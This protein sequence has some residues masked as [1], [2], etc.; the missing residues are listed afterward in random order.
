[1]KNFIKFSLFI[2]SLMLCTAN[3]ADLKVTTINPIPTTPP[4]LSD[5]DLT[6]NVI[7]AVGNNHLAASQ[8][9]AITATNG[10]ITLTGTVSNV[11]DATNFIEVVESVTGVKDV[12]T[13]SL[14]LV[15]GL[16]LPKDRVITAKIRGTFI[17]ENL[18][19]DP[20][21]PTINVN[22]INGVVYIT[23]LADSRSQLLYSI[24]LIRTVK[25]VVNIVSQ[26]FV[27][28]L[29]IRVVN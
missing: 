8:N 19:S 18:F 13:F 21:A 22:T 16:P 15:G 1:M 12:N 2:M 23:G 14:T 28:P 29:L 17:R 27:K 9:I 5:S 6:S 20:R 10:V 3:F 25:G 4:P 24:V 26:V 11:E 7:A